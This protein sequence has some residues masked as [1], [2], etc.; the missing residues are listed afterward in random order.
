[1]ICVGSMVQVGEEV[2]SLLREK[3]EN[4]TLV[5]ARFVKP[6][7]TDLLKELARE[8]SL[9]V[10]VEENV[11]NGGFGEHVASYMEACHPGVR[12]LPVAIWDRFVEHGAVESLRAKTGLSTSSI[13]EA[14]EEYR[15]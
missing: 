3:G 6:I 8:H 2:C 14:I 7:D 11:K 15:A 12:V 9:F 5:N 1:M 10:T 13:L 4:P